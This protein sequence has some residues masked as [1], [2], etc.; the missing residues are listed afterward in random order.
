M[1]SQ[2]V[3]NFC[4]QFWVASTAN[5]QTN[6]FFVP[7]A[8]RILASSGQATGDMT[9]YTVQ[10]NLFD[11]DGELVNEV[12][13]S[14]PLDRVGLLELEPLL[15]VCKYEG[16]M[17]HGRALISSD[18]PT[19]HLCRLQGREN[20]ALMRELLPLSAQHRVFLPV[21]L[22][23]AKASILV[24]SNMG[25]VPAIL[26]CKLIVGKRSP[27]MQLEIPAGATR[28][29]SVEN[30]FPE[31]GDLNLSRGVQGFLRLSSRAEDQVG[32]QLLERI[33]GPKDT[34]LF[35]TVS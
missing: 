16:G 17:K 14:F 9:M 20:A 1:Q 21:S 11:A 6:L 5:F 2:S 28:L 32:V 35:T 10:L 31:F 4:S 18:S 8:S 23:E 29:L 3:P 34:G 15:E 7:D 30:E 12:T 22:T 25:R 26:R 13:T 33:E 27:E 24:L 19:K